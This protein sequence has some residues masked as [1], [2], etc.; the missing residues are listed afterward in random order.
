[1]IKIILFKYL[2]DFKYHGKIPSQY[3][4]VIV[5]TFTNIKYV[6]NFILNENYT[7]YKKKK[8]IFEKYHSSSFF[9]I[10]HYLRYILKIYLII[11]LKYIFCIYF[12]IFRNI[13][14]Y[15]WSIIHKIYKI[16][17]SFSIW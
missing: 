10:L 3:D 15:F 8:E 5:I 2:L 14:L 16:Y 13:Y 4:K 7:I 6:I 1:M 17:K 9:I 11:Y 12:N